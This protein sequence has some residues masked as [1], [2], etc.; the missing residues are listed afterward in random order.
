MRQKQIRSMRRL[1]W[2]IKQIAAY[3]GCEEADVRR[4][5]KVRRA[6]YV[7]RDFGRLN[8]I[9]A[10]RK[11]VYSKRSVMH[12]LERLQHDEDYEP[13]AE[14]EFEPCE[15]PAGSDEKIV[16]LM[17]RAELGLPLYHPKDNPEV[18]PQRE[19]DPYTI[20]LDV[21]LHKAVTN[22]RLMRGSIN[23]S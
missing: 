2:T 17:R 18:L 13:C 1:G 12:C 14:C 11:D 19:A 3:F 22:G 4:K 5:L 8:K 16:E 23:K 7:H 21:D 15:H 6:G 20:P 9:T 10:E